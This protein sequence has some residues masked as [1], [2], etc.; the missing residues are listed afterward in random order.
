MLKV[1]PSGHAMS[2]LRLEDMYVGYNVKTSILMIV[3]PPQHSSSL[4]FVH[5]PKVVS[6]S[7]RRRRHHRRRRH[8]RHITRCWATPW[9]LIEEVR[10]NLCFA[11]FFSTCVP[12]GRSTRRCRPF[13]THVDGAITMEWCRNPRTHRLARTKSSTCA[14]TSSVGTSLSLCLHLC[15]TRLD[16]CAPILMFADKSAPV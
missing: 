15:G 7:Y 11:T 3:N 4:V 2:A 16:P 14:C 13:W 1:E 10:H 5:K 9:V 6:S 12:R 8:R